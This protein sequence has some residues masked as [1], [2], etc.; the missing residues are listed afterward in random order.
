MN[1]LP[2]IRQMQYLL[3][4]Y[5]T[6]NFRRAAEICHITQPTLSAA[7]KE[8]EIL[9]G[10]P[11]LDRSRKKSVIF[12]AFGE[13][14]I[15]TAK[16]IMPQLD[17]LIDKA[18]QMAQP[19]SGPMRLG[20]IPTIAPYLLPDILPDLQ[21]KFRN[22]DFQIVEDMSANLIKKLHAGK[23]DMAVLAFPY[24]T[25]GLNQMTF[26][27]EPFYCAV[28]KGVFSKD[29]K[30]TL[31]DLDNHKLLLLEDG[32][33]LRDHALSACK[34][35]DIEDKKT[36]SATSLLTLIQMVSQGYGITLLPEMV[37]NHGVVPK[38]LSLHS[39]KKPVPS[40]KIGVLWRQ[41]DPHEKDI[42]TV[43]REMKA[44]LCR[45]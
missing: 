11:V 37:L 40:R 29:Q 36:L 10:L 9:L 3:T 34:M 45:D 38:N 35:Q 44:V 41:K 26:F 6:R 8:M 17:H 7:I 22:I 30:L 18:K 20:L 31:S 12:T 39:F 21:K 23:I 5:E 42:K 43:I 28:Q 15:D 33:C 4:L 2:T 24:E 16:T 32:H 25:D 14:V 13:E 27:E 19:L 1:I